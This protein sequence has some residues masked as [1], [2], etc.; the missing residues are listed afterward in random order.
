MNRVAE[1][2]KALRE[3]GKAEK[4]TRG[5]GYYYFRDGDAF[6]WPTSSVFVYRADQLTIK[7]WLAEY[8]RLAADQ[9]EYRA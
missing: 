5:R 9:A 8:A 2:N 1:V 6:A 4:L 3:M 7:E